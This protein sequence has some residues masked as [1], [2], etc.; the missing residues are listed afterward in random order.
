MVEEGGEELYQGWKSPVEREREDGGGGV[1][2]RRK[3]DAGLLGFLS[4]LPLKKS[5][6][7]GDFL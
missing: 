4:L 2:G 6:M 5:Q 3:M 1:S 7:Y